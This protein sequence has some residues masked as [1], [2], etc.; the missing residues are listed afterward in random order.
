MFVPAGEDGHL[1][2]AKQ[3]DVGLGEYYGAV[4]ITDR[5]N[6]NEGVCEV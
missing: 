6:T 2:R 3:S 4:G 1:L 5:T